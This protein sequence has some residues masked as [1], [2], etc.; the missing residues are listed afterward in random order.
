MSFDL[1]Q[2]RQAEKPYY[3]EN[4]NTNIYSIEELQALIDEEFA[5]LDEYLKDA[6]F[7]TTKLKELL[8]KLKTR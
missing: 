2:V 1:C 4:I 3:I 7:D 8:Y 6:S 5:Q